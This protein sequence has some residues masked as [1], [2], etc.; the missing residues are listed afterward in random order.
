MKKNELSGKIETLSI[1][2]KIALLPKKDKTLLL[3]LL[4][5]SLLNAQLVPGEEQDQ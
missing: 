2:E 5:S 1:E 3:K 4:T